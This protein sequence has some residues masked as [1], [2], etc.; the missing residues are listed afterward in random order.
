MILNVYKIKNQLRSVSPPCIHIILMFVV[1]LAVFFAASCKEKEGDMIIIPI[2]GGVAHNA[3]SGTTYSLSLLVSGLDGILVLQNNGGDDDLTVADN[4]YHTFATGL[5][6]D[7]TYDVT[8]LHRPGNQNCNVGN[9][10]GSIE[11]ANISNVTVFCSNKTWKYPSGLFDNIAPDGPS[12]AF[13]PQV[14]MDNNGNAIIVWWQ[15]NGS[16]FQ[17]FKSEYRNGSWS[18]PVGL[19][20][21]ISPNGQD[22]ANPQVAMDNNGNA[23]IVWHQNSGTGNQIYKSEYRNGSWSHPAYLSDNISPDGSDARYPRVA[24]DNNGNAIIVWDQLDGSNSQIFKSE[25]RNG[26][27]SHPTDLSNNI[28]PD[29]QNAYNPK[30]VMDG[31]G[32]SIIV[33]EQQDGINFQIFKSEY[34]N[35]S[36][37]HPAQLTDNI[38]LNG[39]TANSPQVAMDNYGNA[40]I[41]WYQNDG[42]NYQIFKSEYRNSGWIHP[43]NLSDN[44]SPDG[45]FAY[46][47]QVAMD[48]NDN[49][50]IVW[51]QESGTGDHIFKSEYRNGAWIHPVGLSDNISLDGQTAYFPVQISMDNAGN[52]I[53]VWNQSDGI[54][55]QIFKSEYRSGSWTHPAHLSDNISPDDQDALEQ[56]VAMD[57]NGNAIIVWRQFNGIQEQIFMSE[58]R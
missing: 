55:K 7:A 35:G 22:A 53:I 19:S 25:Y 36:W 30:V 21:N 34:R 31:N 10:I 11:R 24:M 54:H 12:I 46:N 18:H 15:H 1:S 42:A 50:I 33:W 51:M 3:E 49:A 23:I 44:I 58:Y 56:Q 9:G 47:P 39:Q 57:D 13:D 28:S 32:N 5:T 2:T 40:I 16:N 38:S 20:N 45:K 4:G 29:G 27:W 37:I 26:S 43:A 41:V 14:A 8:I 6:N 52:A 48:D 17:I